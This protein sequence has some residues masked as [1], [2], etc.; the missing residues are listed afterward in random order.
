MKKDVLTKGDILTKGQLGLDQ[1]LKKMSHKTTE[2]TAVYRSPKTFLKYKE[3]FETCIF[4]DFRDCRNC[5]NFISTISN[6][7]IEDS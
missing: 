5:K 3:V 1:L 7:K 2:M 4:G 6:T